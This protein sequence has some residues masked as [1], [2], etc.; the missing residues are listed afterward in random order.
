MLVFPVSPPDKKLLPAS[1][2]SACGSY[3]SEGK[4]SAGD[5]WQ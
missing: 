2:S 5:S 1:A 3:S 4:C